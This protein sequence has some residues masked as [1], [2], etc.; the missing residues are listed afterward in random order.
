MRVVLLEDVRR[1]SC[2]P[3]LALTRVNEQ[4]V[5]L[6]DEEAAA[7]RDTELAILS[8]DL[9]DERIDGRIRGV[10]VGAIQ[11]AQL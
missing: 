5:A 2:A 6:S 8:R 3:R 9:I 7:G 11:S 1:D 4:L 10:S